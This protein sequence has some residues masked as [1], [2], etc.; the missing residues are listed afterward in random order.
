MKKVL[1]ILIGMMVTGE[2]LASVIASGD[3][4]GPTCHWELDDKGHITI[5]GAGSTYGYPNA[6]ALPWTDYRHQITS[7]E[8]QNGITSVGQD[9]FQGLKNVKEVYL[10]PSVTSINNSAFR[11]TG[12]TSIIIPPQVNNLGAGAWSVSWAQSSF[13]EVFCSSTQI[14]SGLCTSE[15]FGGAELGKYENTD[16]GKLMVYNP[17]GSIKGIYIDYATFSQH[18]NVVDSYTK[19]DEEGNPLMVYDGYGQIKKAYVYNPDGSVA[20][21]DKN[22]KL[23]S[24][25]GKKILTVDEATS[26]VSGKNTFSIKYR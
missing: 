16:D 11:G 21:Y 13:S 5:S 14:T 1:W 15:K 17:D 2:A 20:T 23:I 22:G 7:V 8:V 4:C 6:L 10:A 3:N 24:L 25:T 9:S 19:K 26:L 12:I 18:G